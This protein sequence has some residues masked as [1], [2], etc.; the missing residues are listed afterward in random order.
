MG[1]ATEE[2]AR[3]EDR[4]YKGRFKLRG[5]SLRQHAARGTLI[6]SAFLL[7]ISLLGFLKGFALAGLLD[8]DD[9]GIWGI[10][11]VAFGTLT[12]LKQVGI[13]DKYIQ[14]DEEDQELAFQKAF[15][16]ELYFTLLFTLALGLLTPL[17][18]LLYGEPRII[19]PA[20]VTLLVLPAGALQTPLWAYYR[21]MEFGR[22]RM[23]QSVDPLVGLV[24]SV[25]LAA[26]GMGVWALV[27]GLL[28]GAWSA[29]LVSVLASPHKLRLRFERGSLHSYASYS[30]PLFIASGGSLV[31]A[32]TSMICGEDAVG[33]AGAGAITLAA[34]VTQ[35]TDKVDSIM[36]GTLYPAIC[37]V[38]DR[39][40]LLF[41]SFVKSNRL[42]LMWAMPFGVSLALFAPDLVHHVIGDKWEEAIPLLQVMGI[43]AAVA[44]LGYNWDAYFRAR[45]DTKPMAVASVAAMVAFLLVGIPGLYLE[46]LDGFALGLW[47][48]ALVHVVVRFHFLGRLFDGFDLTPHAIR[49]VTP[50]V[51]PVA[52]VL[53]VRLVE[54]GGERSATQAALE[55]LLYGALTAVSTWLIEGRL[56]REAVRYLRPAAAAS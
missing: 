10:I 54:H 11:V 19:A 48:Q 12:W 20:L 17:L 15:T 3:A 18:A 46:G 22:Q 50:L 1:D 32:Q 4:D 37:A 42:S 51:P 9:Y 31:I 40:D 2:A 30:W 39:T 36:T 28:A 14:Q 52:C 34:Q 56:L 23:L 33:L 35:L 21:K 7:L 25:V 45:G 44:H 53:L 47:A 55:L 24:A 27:L 26:L 29:A 16:L 8:P 6:N 13:G 41:E 43:T 49:A 38:R 5:R